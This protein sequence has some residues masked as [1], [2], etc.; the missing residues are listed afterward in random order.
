MI[1][2]VLPL[3]EPTGDEDA[4]ADHGRKG[5]SAAVVIGG[6]L[7]WRGTANVEGATRMVPDDL[8]WIAS[9]TKMFTA[10]VTLQLIEEGRLHFDDRI[11]QSLPPYETVVEEGG[12]T[13]LDRQARSRTPFPSR[14]SRQSR[15]FPFRTA[16]Q[17]P[18]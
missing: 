7:R 17:R 12:V 9:I 11:D 1:C 15:W 3:L 4:L 2:H 5:V 16:R 18:P 13:S 10:V 6:E 8:F 14:R